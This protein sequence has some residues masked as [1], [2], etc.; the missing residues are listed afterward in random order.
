MSL[1]LMWCTAVL[2]QHYTI[3]A[4][5]KWL[6][7]HWNAL[8]LSPASRAVH[9]FYSLYWNWQ[10]DDA[11]PGAKSCLR[12]HCCCCTSRP[13]CLYTF[14][15]L[16][17]FLLLRLTWGSVN[18]K[19]KW[20]GPHHTTLCVQFKYITLRHLKRHASEWRNK[21]GVFA[22]WLACRSPI[23]KF[24]GSQARPVQSN[25]NNNKQ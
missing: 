23:P 19:Q 2:M 9:S 14:L 12:A 25:H 16:L 13:L 21:S 3:S 4:V 8:S 15:L 5:A 1:F 6:C 11:I 17:L 18:W 10:S 22:S 24:A 7:Q 20:C